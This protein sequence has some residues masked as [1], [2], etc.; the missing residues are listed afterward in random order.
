[1]LFD[2]DIQIIFRVNKAMQT[3]YAIIYINGVKF[4]DH[5]KLRGIYLTRTVR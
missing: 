3:A 1:M 4:E 2:E 5:E